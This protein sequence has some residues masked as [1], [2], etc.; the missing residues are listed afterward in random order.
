MF[1]KIGADLETL[2]KTRL[3]RVISDRGGSAG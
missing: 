2:D 1:E 3:E